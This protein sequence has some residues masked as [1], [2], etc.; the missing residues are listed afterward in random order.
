MA[1]EEL[2]LAVVGIGYPNADGSSRLEELKLC[3]RE[4]P[5]DLR[6]E[7]ENPHDSR[8][9]AVFSARGVQIGYLPVDR[10][11][12]IFRRIEEGEPAFAVFQEHMETAA[13][14][15][16]RFGGEDPSLPRRRPGPPVTPNPRPRRPISPVSEWYPDPEGPEWGA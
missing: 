16:L 8:A 5:V 3:K 9:V 2:S 1:I 7:P 14:I 11:G 12:W 10:A 13:V 4:E 6:L 15:R